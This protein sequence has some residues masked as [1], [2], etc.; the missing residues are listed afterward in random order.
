MQRASGVDSTV[1][2]AIQGLVV[3]FVAA[4][5]AIKFSDSRWGK[6]LAQRRALEAQLTSGE[7][8]NA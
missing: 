8:Q 2:D 7:K 5:L 4:S 1:I 6:I 3:I